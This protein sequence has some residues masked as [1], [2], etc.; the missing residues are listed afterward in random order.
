MQDG[1]RVI[2]RFSDHDTSIDEEYN[3]LIEL[4]GKAIFN[5]PKI[6]NKTTDHLTFEYIKGT[7]A[8]NLLVDLKSLYQR[9][10]RNDYIEIASQL[11]ELLSC[12]LT[13][14]QQVTSGIEFNSCVNKT[15]KAYDKVANIYRLLIDVLAIELNFDDVKEDLSSITNTYIKNSQYCFRDASVKNAILNIPELF[16]FN[17]QN[18]EERLKK[19]ADLVLSGKMIRILRDDIVYHIDFSSCLSK[20]PKDDDW[21]ALKHHEASQWLNE[22]ADFEDC[23]DSYLCTKFVRFSRFGGRKIAYRLLNRTGYDIRFR[24]DNEVYYFR[25][26]KDICLSLKEKGLIQNGT[27][28]HLMDKLIEACSYYPTY[29]Y[30]HQY[31]SNSKEIK[32][33]SDV[34]PN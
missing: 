3:F 16:L 12:Q 21:I 20:C 28:V 1:E 8:F 7:R 26:L 11:L 19:I 30:L 25:Q 29:D 22:Q 15:Y 13:Q 31:L 4:Q 5:T 18:Y 27:L 32:Y 24:F 6:L 33:Y 14:F 10:K 34:F 2:N 23:S 17:G 9:D